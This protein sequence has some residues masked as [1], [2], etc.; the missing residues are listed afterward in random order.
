VVARQSTTPRP[1]LSKEGNDGVIFMH[2][3]EPKDHGI[4]ARND[5][6]HWLFHLCSCEEGYDAKSHIR[7][8]SQLRSSANSAGSG[9]AKL[10]VRC[11][12]GC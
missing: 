5:T 7:S 1:L 4:L 3:R 12:C 11:I 6:G 10:T 2:S 8:E 9:A